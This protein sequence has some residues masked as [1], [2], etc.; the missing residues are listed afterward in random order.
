MVD[1]D[2]VTSLLEGFD[3]RLSEHE[4]ALL[5]HAR[6][7]CDHNRVP[8]YL[9]GG[10]VRDLLLGLAHLDLD[11]A[12]E[13]DAVALATA[14]A[15]ALVAE[16]TTYSHFGTATVT[17]RDRSVDIART[18][19]ERYAYP[20]TL[21]IVSP[22]PIE[23]DMGRR[24]FTVNALAL[25]MAGGAARRLIDPFDGRA[26]LKGRLIRVLYGESFRDDPT[27]ILRM[28]RYTARLQFEVDPG[29]LAAGKKAA[30]FLSVLSPARIT[31]E[32]ERM[33][34]EPRP[35]DILLLLRELHALS[36]IYP[37]FRLSER[38]G[39]SFQRLRADGGTAPGVSEYLCALAAPWGR[40]EIQ[41][42]AN[43][44]ELRQE[45][46]AALLDLRGAVAVLHEL[47][48]KPLDPATV[49]HALSRFQPAAVRGAGA[50]AGGLTSR[51]V[52]RFVDEWR[53]VAPLLRGDDVI[54]MG[55]PKGPPV[56]EVLKTLQAG[57]LRGELRNE[58]DER[59]LV[60]AWLAKS[61]RTGDRNER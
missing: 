40:H 52:R 29:T 5:D 20:G 55:V 14:I 22:A 46:R 28:A 34:A 53:N 25:G 23:D 4:R 31:H 58:D 19:S 47:S 13:G 15:A 10:S 36:P 24:D 37:E 21:P 18:R 59:A 17:Y 41:G 7:W 26:D 45:E 30:T 43:A 8:L 54:S 12:V 9:V 48:S 57:R 61:T 51:I 27:R 2:N 60:R 35:E 3:L 11:L 42:L 1:M 6:A 32:F 44:L 38:L 39:E 56:G 33:F 49:T 16:V 50:A